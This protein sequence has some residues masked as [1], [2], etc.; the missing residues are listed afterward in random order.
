MRKCIEN[1]LKKYLYKM[2]Q[3][4]VLY[5]YEVYLQYIYLLNIYA[6]IYVNIIKPSYA[7]SVTQNYFYLITKE[8]NHVESINQ[9]R[10]G[11]QIGAHKE[12][13]RKEEIT[14]REKRGKNQLSL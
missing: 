4:I 1:I 3:S 13:D 10:S 14:L 7:F 11:S 2:K 6:K 8:F 5:L 9:N 12:K